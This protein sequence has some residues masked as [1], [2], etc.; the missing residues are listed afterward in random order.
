MQ[1]HILCDTYCKFGPV[2]KSINNMYEKVKWTTY[3]EVCLKD[4]T[5]VSRFISKFV[6]WSE[7]V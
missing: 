3:K 6:L 5:N 2:I 4:I 7:K 1:R